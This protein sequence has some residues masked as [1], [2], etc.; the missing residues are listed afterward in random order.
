LSKAAKN[1]IFLI[2]LVMQSS[3]AISQVQQ[4]ARL[5]IPIGPYDD[6]EC[7]NSGEDGV[8]IVKANQDIST[9]QVVWDIHFVD[10][11]LNIKNRVEFRYTNAM[12]YLMNTSHRGDP[13]F[14]FANFERGRLEVIRFN[15]PTGD[16]TVYGILNPFAYTLLDFHVTDEAALL[17]GYYNE[18]P[19]I[20]HHSFRT[21]RVKVVPGLYRDRSQLVQVEV[22]DDASFDVMVQQP[23]ANRRKGLMIRRY[24]PQGVLMFES[25]LAPVDKNFLFGR[26][27]SLPSGEIL[28]TGTWTPNRTEFSRGIF[29]ANIS[30]TG[31]NRIRYYNYADL[32]NFFTY[33]RDGKEARVKRRIE[34]RKIKGKRLKFSYRMLVHNLLEADDTYVML[35]EAFY[36]KYTPIYRATYAYQS[37]A[38]NILEGYQYTHAVVIGFD[39]TGNLV[40]DNSFEIQD[41]LTMQLRQYVYADAGED[42]IALLYS[43]DEEI[44]TKYIRQEEMVDQKDTKPIALRY[45]SDIL[46]DSERTESGFERWFGESYYA[47]GVQNIKNGIDTEV[48]RNRRVFYLNKITHY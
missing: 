27:L 17:S 37:V 45:S 14:L 15:N 30:L 26:L 20:L 35:G 10:T 32:E 6:I 2:V 8:Y 19:V 40:W 23:T 4:P 7:F 9:R 43:I 42:E 3:M 24:S 33:M 41:V 31:A 13:Y 11:S 18:K 22:N 39:K 5:E 47:Y 48:A 34:R 21:G 1:I 12:K 16:T 28:V 44:R 36:P 38:A 25:K 46:I 29:V